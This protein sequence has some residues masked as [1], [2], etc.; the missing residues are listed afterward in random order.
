MVRKSCPELG[1]DLTPDKSYPGH[2]IAGNL[3]YTVSSLSRLGGHVLNHSLQRRQYREALKSYKLRPCRG[4]LDYLF[5]A[6]IL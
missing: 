4:I 3:G 2:D 6:L 5:C 1:F